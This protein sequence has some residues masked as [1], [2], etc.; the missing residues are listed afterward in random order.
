MVFVDGRSFVRLVQSNAIQATREKDPLRTRVVVLFW[1]T[2]RQ[3]EELKWHLDTHNRLVSEK[4]NLLDR[5]SAGTFWSPEVIVF[6]N[7]LY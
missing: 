6:G 4:E 2:Q 7:H 1:E 3:K 5:V